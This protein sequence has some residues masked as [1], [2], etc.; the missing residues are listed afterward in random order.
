M[1]TLSDRKIRDTKPSNK[2]IWLN[3]GAGLY[4]RVRPNG[5]KTFVLRQKRAGNT[6]KVTLGSFP[7]MGIA[8]AR[9]SALRFSRNVDTKRID[10]GTLLDEWFARR[11]EP[12][13][14]VT[15]NIKTYVER[16]KKEFGSTPLHRLTTATL[17]R[18]LQRYA[19]KYPIAA[20][21]CASSLKLALS[22][23]VECGYLAANPLQGTT[24]R[25]IGGEEKTRDRTLTDAEIAAL[26][27]AGQK[28]LRFLLLTG[29][30]I[31]EG[32]R[33]AADGNC[34]RI[35]RTK[36][37]D[38]HWVHLPTLAQD[39]IQPFDTSPTAVQSWLKRWCERSKI[40]PFTPHDLRRTFATRLAGLGVE[41]YIIEKCLN[42]RMQGV[43]AIYNR[44]DYE[45]ERIAA[46][47][48]WAA[49]VQRIIA[50]SETAA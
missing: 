41:P 8:E 26:W 12:N 30:R 20:N 15:K 35:E 18:W 24:A 9:E 6:T 40:D 45:A 2:D 33:G 23:A 19:E 42:H 43:M 32:Q 39:Q 48:K 4:C 3:D 22:Y 36:N 27:A 25:V 29:L 46:A 10:F 44:H 7:L 5:T 11:I 14:R 38:A 34:Y 47:E 49:E 31:S 37:G 13:Y 21:R 28:L 1:A 16:A 50:I 17:V